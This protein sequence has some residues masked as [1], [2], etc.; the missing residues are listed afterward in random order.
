[1]YYT[2]KD[3]FYEQRLKE[4]EDIDKAVLDYQKQFSENATKKEISQS[5]KSADY[6]GLA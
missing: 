3:V 2:E 6:L 5:K 4:W 1:M